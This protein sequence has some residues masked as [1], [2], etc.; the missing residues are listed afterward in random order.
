[1]KKMMTLMLGMALAF[2]SVALTF[3]QDAPTKKDDS[4]KKE[5][6][7]KKGGKKKDDSK[8]EGTR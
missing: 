6:T 8:K 4:S 3:A 5:N 7:K 1:M 2:T